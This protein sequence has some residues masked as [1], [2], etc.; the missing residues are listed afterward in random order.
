MSDGVT[1]NPRY[2]GKRVGLIVPSVNAVIE[3]DIAWCNPEGISFHAAR[4]MLR[5]TTPDGLR[6]MNKDVASASDL[7]ASLSPD[8]VAYACT[9]GS[10]LDGKEAL[11]RLMASIEERVGCKVVSTS[12]SM[13]DAFSALKLKRVAVM[14]PYLD[15][16]N[17]AERAFIEQEGFEVTEIVGMGLS[18]PQIR[19]VSPRE[20]LALARSGMANNADGLFISCTDFRALETIS[21]LEEELGKPVLTSNQVTLRAILDACGYERPMPSL[22]RYLATSLSGAGDD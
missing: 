10:F 6:A 21:E 11:I 5:D 15:S 3:P 22:G 9:S 17:G 13:I 18:G 14:T 19:E 12:Q 7:L 1:L 8:V 2:G 4:I 20:I 16:V